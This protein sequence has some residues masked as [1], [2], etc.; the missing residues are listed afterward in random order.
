M[1]SGNFPLKISHECMAWIMHAPCTYKSCSYVYVYVCTY[2]LLECLLTFDVQ[3][4]AALRLHT[5]HLKRSG[6]SASRR[7]GRASTSTS[8]PGTRVRSSSLI[9]NL[10]LIVS[11]LHAIIELI[12]RFDHK[13][14]MLLVIRVVVIICVDQCDPQT[15]AGSF[16]I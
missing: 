1:F 4:P 3:A 9:T 6:P 15:V 8:T 5:A 16:W 12:C 7:M 14:L 13:L 10:Q 2:K 11:E